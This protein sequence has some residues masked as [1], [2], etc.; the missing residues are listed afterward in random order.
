MFK[1]IFKNRSFLSLFSAFVIFIIIYFFSYIWIFSWIN[2]RISSTFISV[3][4]SISEKNINE[5]IVVVTIDEKTTNELWAFP[6]DRKYYAELIEKLN[7]ANASVIGLDIIFADENKQ[8]LQSDEIFAE[9]IKKAWNVI[10]WG[11]VIVEDINNK[12]SLVIEKP[13]KKFFENSAWFW[14]YVPELS[15]NNTVLT[16]KPTRKI[17]DKDLVVS[18]YNH[19]WV[20]ILKVHYWKIYNKDFS[21]NFWSDANFFYLRENDKIPFKKTWSDEVLINFVPTVKNNQKLS[22][23][24]N[25][26]FVDILEWKIDPKNFEN[27]IILVWATAKWLKD[28]FQTVNG[29]EYGVFVHANI[30]NTISSKNFLYYYPEYLEWTLIILVIIT[31]IYFSLSSSWKVVFLANLSIFIIFI[32]ILPIFSITFLSS[33]VY[34]HLFE[35]FLAL[36]FSIAVWNAVKF[37]FE[38]NNRYKLSKA[39]SEYVSKAIVKD[40]LKSNWE[41]KLDWE[42]RKLTI[43]FSDIEWFTSISEK[44]SPQELV[45]FLREY[46]SGMSNI[47]LDENWFINK[48]EWDAIMALWW[49]FSEHQKDSYNA[50]FSAIS[51]QKKLK[52]L[53]KIWEKRWLPEI[54]ARIWLHSWQAIVWN[55]WAVWRKIEYTA[56]WDSVNL[57]SRLEWINKFYGTFICASEVVYEENK[58]FFEFRFL[59]N[60]TVKWKE[61]PIKIYELIGMKEEVSEEQKEKIKKFEE[62][63]KIY[64]EKDFEK[65]KEFFKNNFEKYD[66][67]PSKTYVERCEFYLSNPDKVD[68]NLIWKYETK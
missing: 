45:A 21:K 7:D 43:F 53:N 67:K 30:I 62:A 14:Y 2:E 3:K 9:S 11:S 27:K 33:Y 48:Y 6:F 15:K 56:L 31:S 49:T 46:L 47:I 38:S 32:I 58:E 17:A 68:E 24:T 54:K 1:E 18:D 44:F 8:N 59:D 51:Q 28:I 40:I 64:N 61:L 65:A 10:L 13:V 55:I 42:L 63:M 39:L 34:L 4:N 37:I 29:I 57:A 26:S 12:A 52:E 5:D 66:D 36:P 23:F 25:Y 35:L 16:F 20:E 19:F 50:C 60:I 41:I 22:H